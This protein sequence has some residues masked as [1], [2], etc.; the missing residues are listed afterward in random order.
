MYTFLLHSHNK[1]LYVLKIK[2][3]FS[4]LILSL[5][6]YALLLVKLQIEMKYFCEPFYA[7]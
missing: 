7:V 6:M 3:C 4:C 5:C 2:K 1:L